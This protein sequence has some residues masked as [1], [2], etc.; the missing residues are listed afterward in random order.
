MQIS[1]KN[2]ICVL[3]LY[4]I[5]IKL[6]MFLLFLQLKNCNFF[7]FQDSNYSD[8]RKIISKYKNNSIDGTQIHK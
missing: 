7:Q 8:C 5:C 2:A 3:P 4:G 1:E 6:N